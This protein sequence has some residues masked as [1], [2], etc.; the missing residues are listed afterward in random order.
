LREEPPVPTL[1]P[2][3]RTGGCLCGHIRWEATGKPSFPHLCS[4]GQ[5]R[6]WSGALTVAWVDLPLDGFRWTGPGGE[7]AIF[8]SSDRTRRGHCPACGSA[9]CALDDGSDRIAL[10]IA[11]LDEPNPIMP[12][13]QHSFRDGLPPWWRVSIEKQHGR[14]GKASAAAKGAKPADAS[15]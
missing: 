4:C 10:T 6:R 5:C 14:R 12:G 2:K 1:A 13:R 9:L 15:P 11:T 8:R 7:P 3:L